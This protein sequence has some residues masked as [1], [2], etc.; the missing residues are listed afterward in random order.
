MT[1]TLF[2]VI[3]PLFPSCQT[4]LSSCHQQFAALNAFSLCKGR[5]NTGEGESTVNYSKAN[6]NGSLPRF[7]YKSGI[8]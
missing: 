3:C 7:A 1:H 5:V 4:P 2:S 6:Y 8:P